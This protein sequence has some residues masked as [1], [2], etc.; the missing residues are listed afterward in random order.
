MVRWKTMDT[1]SWCVLKRAMFLSR[2]NLT[3]SRQHTFPE[4]S[5]QQIS[6]QGQGVGQHMRRKSAI[7]VDPSVLRELAGHRSLDQAGPVSPVDP[8]SLPPNQ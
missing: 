8:D 6:A 5:R 1:G 3:P 4:T 2:A 7:P